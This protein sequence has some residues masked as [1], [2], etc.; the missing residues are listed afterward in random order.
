MLSLCFS[1]MDEKIVNSLPNSTNAVESHNRFERHLHREDMARALEVLAK[2][3]GFTSYKDISAS[4]RAKRS[5][6]QNL[7]IQKMVGTDDPEWPP[8]RILYQ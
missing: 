5:S 4:G 6:Q 7:A 3:Q 2:R 1:D 8:D